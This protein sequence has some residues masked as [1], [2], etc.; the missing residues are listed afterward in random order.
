M[1]HLQESFHPF[2]SRQSLSCFLSHMAKR[3]HPKAARNQLSPKP[4]VPQK[5]LMA[6]APG[7]K[8]QHQSSSAASFPTPPTISYTCQHSHSLPA[9][10]GC[11]SKS[12]QVWPLGMEPIISKLSSRAGT[13][14]SCLPVTPSLE[15]TPISL[16]QSLAVHL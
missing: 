9:L 15:V 7:F 14:G 5:S 12:G 11:H 3:E 1:A 4:S 8:S 2:P 10:L 6:A 16:T 13:R